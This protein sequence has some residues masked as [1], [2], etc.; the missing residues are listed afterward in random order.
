MTEDGYTCQRWDSQY[1]QQHNITS[2]NDEENYCRNPDNDPLGP[3][4]YTTDFEEPTGYCDI[5]FCKGK[6]LVKNSKI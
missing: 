6:Y 2:L 1:P 5:A 4:C 3:W